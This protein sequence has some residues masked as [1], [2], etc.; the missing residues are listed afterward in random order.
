MS[1]P[2]IKLLNFFEKFREACKDKRSSKINL[3]NIMQE[4]LLCDNEDDVFASYP[5][6]SNQVKFAFDFLEKN[7]RHAPESLEKVR[8]HIENSINTSRALLYRTLN[9]NNNDPTLYPIYLEQ[10]NFEL[11]RSFAN[12]LPDEVENITQSDVDNLIKEIEDLITGLTDKETSFGDKL[13]LQNLLKRMILTLRNYDK[14]S[15]SDELLGDS[16]S[17]FYNF[18]SNEKLEK[19]RDFFDKAKK[20]CGKIFNKVKP[21]KVEV[22]ISLNPKLLLE[23]NNKADN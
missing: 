4:A 15:L 5:M 12:G 7:T 20:I 19:D 6:I 1:A 10:T 3:M 23:Y 14:F 8:L 16:L 11:F 2:V 21:D 18:S 17:L 22:E 13:Y 9:D